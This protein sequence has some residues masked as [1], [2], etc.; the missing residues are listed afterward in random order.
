MKLFLSFTPKRSSSSVNFGKTASL[1]VVPKSNNQR[2]N[3]SFNKTVIL[4][5]KNRYPTA[6]KIPKE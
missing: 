6:I 1:L 4:L 5:F 3:D 2:A